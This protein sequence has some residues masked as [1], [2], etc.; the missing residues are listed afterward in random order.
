MKKSV[1][2]FCML[3][4][5]LALTVSSNAQNVGIGTNTPNTSAIL[6]VKSTNKGIL[7]PQVSLTSLTDI[8]TITTPA[9]GLLVY[10]TNAGLS[11][12]VGFYYN[13]GTTGA[14]NWLKFQTGAGSGWALTGNTGTDSTLNFIGTTNVKPL[15]FRVNNGYAGMIG[16]QGTIALGRG[17]NGLN[18][19]SSPSLIAIGDSALYN[20]NDSSEIAIGDHALFNNGIIAGDNISIGNFS[21]YTNT[22]GFGNISMGTL[23]NASSD[24]ADFNT[25]IGYGAFL[26]G[27]RSFNTAIGAF[28]LNLDSIGTQNTAVGYSAM[29]NNFTGNQNTAVGHFAL[30]SNVNGFDNNAVGMFALV[31]NTN[32]VY[33][34]AVGFQAMFTNTTG[35]RNNAFGN[36]ALLNNTTGSYNSAFGRTTLAANTTGNSNV[37]VGNKAL[38]INQTGSGNTAVGDSSFAGATTIAFSN[39]TAIGYLANVTASNQVRIGN[40]A[41][42]SIGGFAGWTNVSD[43]RYKKDIVEDVKGLDFILKLRPVTYLFNF[44]KLQEEANAGKSASNL[45]GDEALTF[46]PNSRSKASIAGRSALTIGKSN[47]TNNFATPTISAPAPVETPEM[48]AYKALVKKNETVRHTGF[49]AQEVEAAANQV[50][51]DFDGVDKPQHA[52]DKYGLRYAEFVVPLVKAVQEQ[53]AIIDAQNRKIEDLTKRVE[54]LEQR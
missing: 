32:G 24:T 37:A 54:R 9:T 18:K 39:S 1:Q 5:A 12:G 17:A 16:S 23:S 3:F 11:G 44:D 50:G 25:T 6:D 14:A 43:G 33:N 13:G 31:G 45:K 46:T 2:F 34:N 29:E 10:N 22:T 8:V 30:Y 36:N 28:A 47:A 52:Q 41:V 27:L 42:T 26:Y 19:Y 51:F 40:N 7:I 20:A 49:I 15:M 48:A 38:S 53:Q 35:T 4:I 21:M